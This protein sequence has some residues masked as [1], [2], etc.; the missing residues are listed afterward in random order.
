[1]SF[2]GSEYLVIVDY[3]LQD[4]NRPKDAH[5]PLHC[6]KDNHTLKGTVC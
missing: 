3:I 5:I 2:D 4:A 1:M 6:S